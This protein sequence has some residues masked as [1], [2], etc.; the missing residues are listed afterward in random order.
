[1]T[2]TYSY[3]SFLVVCF[4]LGHM[5]AA[6]VIS[7]QWNQ[8]VN[9]NGNMALNKITF[10]DGSRVETYSQKQQQMIVNQNPSPLSPNHVVGSTGQPF[11][12]L[13][14][15]SMTI[16][17]NNASNLVGGQIELS[18]DPT[19]LRQ[20]NISP[21]NA[22]V[23]MLSPG[24]QAW[25]VM[26]GIK[27]VNTTDNTVRLV[28]MTNIDGEY[29]AIGRQSTESANVLTPFADQSVKITG[30]GIQEA[31]FV[32]GFRMSMKATQ[33][34]RVTTNVINGVSS[35]M[36]T[37]PGMMPINNYRY[38]ITTN[39][40]AVAPNLNQ[41]TVILQMPL[42]MQRVMAMATQMGIGAN[43]A[44]VVGISQRTV[45]QNPGGAAVLSPSR[46]TRRNA[47]SK[48]SPRPAGSNTSQIG[49][50]GSVG[51][52]DTSAASETTPINTG[53]STSAPD[54]D[55]DISTPRSGSSTETGGTSNGNRNP[56]TS[57][58]TN[59][60][61]NPNSSGNT[62]G[63]TSGNRSGSNTN[64]N[65]NTNTNSDT[66]GN[67]N[68][69]TNSNTNT[70]TNSGNG[71][72]ANPAATQLLLDPTFRAVNSTTAYDPVTSRVMV[73]VNQINGEFILTMQKSTA[74][75]TAG[76]VPQG[77]VGSNGVGGNGTTGAGNAKRATAATQ[78]GVR[79]TM[80]QVK[81]LMEQQRMGNSL[82]MA[83]MEEAL[84][85]VTM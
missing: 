49:A 74:G 83:M 48:R 53:S 33:P 1:M 25:I 11:V 3:I 72:A 47:R 2:F 78:G 42:N 32:D 12:A 76:Q 60:N 70:N 75:G 71:Q 46:K 31:E 30:S 44:I 57:G 84:G 40:A 35:S 69:E 80:A 29:I 58:N 38:L 10:P 43:E 15:N 81:T 77:G 5:V 73:A 59:G 18:I 20:N 52:G 54:D 67:T 39:L 65:T 63:G 28:K 19:I 45:Q 21:D 22:F 79:F 17:T 34:M 9:L 27:S 7:A 64:T 50:P 16:A 82:P 8:V 24:R 61:R 23:A 55:D 66:N 6:Q 51:T 68:A 13:S 62:S 14:Q 36:I 56:N 4:Q 37:D 85:G 26:E 41:M